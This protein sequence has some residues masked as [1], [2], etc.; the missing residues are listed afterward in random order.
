MTPLRHR[1]PWTSRL[2]ASFTALALPKCAQISSSTSTILPRLRSAWCPRPKRRRN[3]G[4]E[5]SGIS[6]SDS[7]LGSPDSV[8]FFVDSSFMSRRASGAD[9]SNP[10]AGLRR[11]HVE[12]TIPPA[13]CQRNQPVRVL[14]VLEIRGHRVRHC[15]G[16][17]LEGHVVVGDIGASLVR[18]PFE[19][20]VYDGW[21][22]RARYSVAR[23]R[24]RTQSRTGGRPT[25]RPGTSGA[26][27]ARETACGKSSSIRNRAI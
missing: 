1:E 27:S 5:S 25:L 20:T 22:G 26:G 7:A 18:I 15:A 23:S 8:P 17:F 14:G 2:S 16:S 4:S 6:S 19:I 24:S 11:D 9:D 21:H 3:R 12:N 13:G 10:G